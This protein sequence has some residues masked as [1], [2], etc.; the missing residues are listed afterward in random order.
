[1]KNEIVATYYYDHHSNKKNALFEVVACYDSW[2]DYD[3]NRA[4]YY[5]VFDKEGHSC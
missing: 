1:M 5:D 3:N 2:D 4:S